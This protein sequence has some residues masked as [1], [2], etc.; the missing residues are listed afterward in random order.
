MQLTTVKYK[1]NYCLNTRNN[2]TKVTRA[3]KKKYEC[4]QL[5]LDQ[6]I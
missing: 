1:I 3:T 6:I 5:K 4:V 2:S